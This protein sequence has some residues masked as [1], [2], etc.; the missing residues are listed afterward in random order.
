V[1]PRKDDET[2]PL[3][4]E[5]VALVAD[6]MEPIIERAVSRGMEPLAAR[7]A[8]VEQRQNKA[9]AI[10]AGLVMAGGFVWSLAGSWLKQKVG[11]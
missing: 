5:D 9:F 7:V 11:L 4:A 10:Y 3:S 2:R 6:L 8:A 1:P